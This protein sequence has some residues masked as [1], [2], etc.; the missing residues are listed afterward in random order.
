[1]RAFYCFLIG[2]VIAA[3]VPLLSTDARRAADDRFPG[4]PTQFEDRALKQLPLTERE[5]RFN[6]NFPGQTARFT[7]GQRE[8]VIRWVAQDTR[9]L[10]PAADCFQGI[11]HQVDYQPIYIDNQGCRWGVFTA[12]KQQ[13]RL[14]VRERI[15]DDAGNNWTDVSAWYWSA[16]SG[17]STGPWW[18]ITIAERID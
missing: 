12:Q 14:K 2:A 8:I 11:G 9:K 13:R 1:M 5:E 6:D 15:F 18:A 16:F 3:C 4:W 7:D 17:T 10:H